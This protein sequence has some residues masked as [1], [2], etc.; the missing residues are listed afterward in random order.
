MSSDCISSHTNI[1]ASIRLSHCL[2]I[3]C[4][5]RTLPSYLEDRKDRIRDLSIRVEGLAAKLLSSERERT[6]LMKE[7]D[8]LRRERLQ[9][10]DSR[11]GIDN[12]RYGNSVA[13][14]QL[15]EGNDGSSSA[16]ASAGRST[17]VGSWSGGSSS[18]A[19]RDR[20]D[21]ERA[22]AL[23]DYGSSVLPPGTV[24][25]LKQA[26]VDLQAARAECEHNDQLL[27][28]KGTNTYSFVE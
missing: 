25:A 22:P 6:M 24:A 23:A 14:N 3:R 15:Q 19:T 8:E 13:R 2:F 18:A 21:L 26:A 1:L 17:L 27:V 4:Y 12:D 28:K 16:P 20:W 10:T 11:N 5:L 9:W 7:R